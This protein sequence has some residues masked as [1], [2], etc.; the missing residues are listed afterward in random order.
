MITTQRTGSWLSL[1][2]DIQ[3]EIDSGKDPQI[4][5]ALAAG[6]A[7]FR[8]L[9]VDSDWLCGAASYVRIFSPDQTDTNEIEIRHRDGKAVIV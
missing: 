7:A 2:N 5:M 6:Y 4:V 9:M 1:Q 3:A 8:E